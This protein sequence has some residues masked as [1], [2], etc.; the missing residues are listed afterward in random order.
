MTLTANAGA[1]IYY[2]LNGDDPSTSSTKYDV[3]FEV[4]K[5]GTTVKAIAVADGAEKA[6]AEATYTIKPEQPVFSDESKT[7]K[8]AFDVT[9]SLPEST[10][11]TSTITTLSV[12]QLQPKAHCIKAPSTSLQRKMVLRLYS[13]LW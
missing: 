11:A 2:T 7:F 1:T 3:P 10:D 8:D 12:Q 13:T 5:S 6:T 9:L 4:T